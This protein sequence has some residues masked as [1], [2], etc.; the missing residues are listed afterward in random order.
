MGKRQWFLLAIGFLFAGL[1]YFAFDIRPPESEERDRVRL[2]NASTT[3]EE[4]LI[5][6][7][8]KILDKNV[9]SEIR[10]LGMGLRE[11]KNAEDSIQLY[12]QL[13]GSW[14]AVNNAVIAGLYAEKVA[15]LEQSAASWGI[16]G[17]TFALASKKEQS[18]SKEQLY[19]IE[20]SRSAFESAI[21]LDPEEVD[22]RV[23]LA[24]TYADFPPKDNP[25]QGIQ[26]LL[27][28]SRNYPDHA[29]VL[30][31]LG[32]FGLQTGQYE[33]AIGRL[34]KVIKMEPDRRNAYCL[35]VEAYEQIGN[36][37]KARQARVKCEQD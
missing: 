24:V 16:A 25:M 13:S 6:D 26:S 8:L 19:A 34:E 35:L 23:N 36:I 3:S 5:R 28:L 2:M 20:R 15:E 4:V 30:Y 10:A 9:Q 32:R 33:K 17:T 14:Y 7:G 29:G 1:I 22:Y 11:A 21:S 31:Q 18:N 27:A 37:E 12:K